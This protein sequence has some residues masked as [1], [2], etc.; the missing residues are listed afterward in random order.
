MHDLTAIYRKVEKV[1]K[2]Y[3]KEYFEYGWNI[4][5]YPNKPKMTDLEV[6]ALSITAE[7]L[8]IDSENL[9]WSKIKKDKKGKDY[10]VLSKKVSWLPIETELEYIESNHLEEGIKEL[11]KK[12]NLPVF[13]N[14]IEAV[15]YMK[16]I[17][18]PPTLHT[19]Q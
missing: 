13:E 15:N 6:I 9:L 2:M 10:Q 12:C 16:K 3:T 4:Q 7:C 19:R 18:Q 8:Q 17:S 11:S 1:L 14:N 5:F